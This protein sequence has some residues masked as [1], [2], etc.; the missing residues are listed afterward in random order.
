MYALQLN[1]LLS[2]SAVELFYCQLQDHP[3]PLHVAEIADIE[4]EI[5]G[6]V[7][8]YGI[9]RTCLVYIDNV[10]SPTAPPFFGEIDIISLDLR[11]YGAAI[12]DSIDNQ[13]T[14]V[15]CDPVRNPERVNYWNEKNARRETK[16][17]LV[18][19]E[20]VTDSINKGSLVDEFAYIPELS[21]Y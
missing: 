17:H 15:V 2:N 18:R 19:L 8:Q 4:F 11:V 21:L 13:V 12:S 7:N 1:T 5:F 9:F 6:Q 16:F 10:K 20:W 3:S 14:H